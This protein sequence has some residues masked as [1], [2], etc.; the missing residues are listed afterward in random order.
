M[1]FVPATIATTE[2][3]RK[4]R[5]S[6]G[7]RTKLLFLALAVLFGLGPVL[8]FG[9]LLLPVAGEAVADGT[10][11]AFGVITVTEIAT[12]G[13]A[14]LWLGLATLATI[15][16]VTAVGDLDHP[17]SILVSTSLRNTVVGLICTELLVF[18]IWLL[19]ISVVLSSAFAYG[20]GTVWPAV[21]GPVV[22]LVL[23]ATT[24]P[25]GFAVGLGIRHLITVYEPIARFRTP[26]LVLVGVAYFG[27]IAMGWFDR[28]T[29]VLFDLFGESPLGWPGHLLLVGLPNVSPSTSHLAVSLIGSVA[30]A[31]L[32][33]TAATRIGAVHWYA[34]PYRNDSET[35]STHRPS[36]SRLSSL[37]E[38]GLSQ[39]VRTVAITAIRRTKRAPIRLLYVA[40]P[41][42]MAAF[43]VDE[44]ARTGT[45]PSHLAVLVSLYVVWGAGALFT[46]NPLGDLGRARPVVLTSTISGRAAVTGQVVASTLVALP[47]AVVVSLGV[48]LV[49]P[50]TLAQTGLLVVGTVVG[51]LVSP[52][53]AIGVGSLFPRF[54]SVRLSSKREA[55]MP[56]KTAFLVYTLGLTVPVGAAA[57][58]YA[59]AADLIAAMLSAL[60]GLAPVL[61][62]TI[63]ASVIAGAAWV[64][65]PLG[66]A[67]PALSY[68]YAIRRFEGYVD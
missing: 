23:L 60:V 54:G 22:V 37:L 5:V 12:G 15:R 11:E 25:V 53:L 46:L 48:G 17:S 64:A 2:F 68:R 26:L 38:P 66:L 44:I 4:A 8:V 45:I 61:E 63:P 16:T 39:P 40:Y 21:V 56:S 35:T 43:F 18:G 13:V 36:S 30:L 47:V 33:V 3:R 14:L 6:V 57:V 19:P 28:V 65:L 49:S 24:F 29:I 41:L 58:I 32:A 10:V 34:D 55:V 50:L 7:D 42:F 9:A 62:A 31:G 27:T 67:A 20:A 51:V 1:A 59:D 52:A